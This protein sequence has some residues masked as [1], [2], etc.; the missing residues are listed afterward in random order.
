MHR[1]LLSRPRSL[2]FILSAEENHRGFEMGLGGGDIG[3]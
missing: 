3:S 1:D 2:N